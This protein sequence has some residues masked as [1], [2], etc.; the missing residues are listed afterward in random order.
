MKKLIN[1]SWGKVPDYKEAE[2][3]TCPTCKRT[4]VHKWDKKKPC[5]TCKGAGEV[6]MRV[7]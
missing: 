1:W 3:V 2:L 4:C 5:P 6:W 7:W